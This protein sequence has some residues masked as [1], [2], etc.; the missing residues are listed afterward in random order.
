MK[1]NVLLLCAKERE[2]ERERE[3]YI[4]LMCSE[5]R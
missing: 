5:N 4:G 3:T 2:R 1:K